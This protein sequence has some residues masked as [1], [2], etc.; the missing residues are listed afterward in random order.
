MTRHWTSCLRC[1]AFMFT[2]GED[3]VCVICGNRAS[4]RLPLPPFGRPPARRFR[5]Y[6]TIQEY[7]YLAG[8]PEDAVRLKCQ[9]GELDAVKK[10][11]GIGWEFWAISNSP[12]EASPQDSLTKEV[13]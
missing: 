5:G 2:D 1:R 10:K 8:L 11:S 4:L 7:A 9:R 6:Y 3:A 13:G 12:A